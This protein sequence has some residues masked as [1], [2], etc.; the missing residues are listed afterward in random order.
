V[1]K[2]ILLLLCISSSPFVS[3]ECQK[4]RVKVQVLGSGGPELTD[5]RASTA[6]L[7]WLD[8]R[9][10]VLVDAG[11]GSALNYEKSGAEL[12]DLEFIVFSHL[13]VD[14]SVDFPAY[15]KAFYF[16][17]RKKN[18]HVFGPTGNRQMPAMTEYVDGLFGSTGVYR[19]LNEY[20]N[21][22][23]N[24]RYQILADNV[25]IKNKH[26]QKMYQNAELS[27][28]AIPVHHGSLPAVAWRINIAGCSLTFSGDM[29]NHYNT[30]IILAKNS[31]LLVAHNAIPE[32]MQG[33]G[34]LLHMPPSE[35]GKIA[36]QAG[37]KKLILSHRM[38]R[39]LKKE[40]QTLNAVRQYYQGTVVFADDLDVFVPG[41]N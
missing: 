26:L 35:I 32:G 25:A 20:V 21:V 30:L 2:I 36:Y 1:D 33:A 18:I 37:I 28:F 4:N 40:K 19:Y 3:A 22:N 12:N 10:V 15:I 41:V 29:S 14:H 39:T 13:H 34:R 16:S 23:Q 11:S 8:N 17:Q 27:L 7:I 24:S 38:Q 6:Y 31:D 9:G 5:N